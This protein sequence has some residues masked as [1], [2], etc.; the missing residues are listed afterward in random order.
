MLETDAKQLVQAQAKLGHAKALF[1]QAMH[2]GLQE[3]EVLKVY[4]VA[5]SKGYHRAAFYLGRMLE[6]ARATLKTAVGYYNQGEAVGD[7]ACKWVS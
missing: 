6:G 2:F 1:L 5:L 7:S 4:Q 3:P